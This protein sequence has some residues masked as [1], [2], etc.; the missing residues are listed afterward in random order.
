MRGIKQVP[1]HTFIL[2]LRIRFILIPYKIRTRETWP[3]AQ[4]CSSNLPETNCF[5]H[6]LPNKKT[7]QTI[8]GYANAFFFFLFAKWTALK[9]DL[10]CS[11]S[12]W[13]FVAENYTEK[14][15]L[16]WKSHLQ[17]KML[18]W[19]VFSVISVLFSALLLSGIIGTIQE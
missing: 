1:F 3:S 8:V 13:K 2:T 6:F 10:R 4:Y 5:Y 16:L 14:S 11:N 12:T 19:K 17:K 7:K 9:S 15:Q 18:H